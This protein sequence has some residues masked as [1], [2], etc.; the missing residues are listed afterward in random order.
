MENLGDKEP[1]GFLNKSIRRKKLKKNQ[2]RKKTKKYV[3]LFTASCNWKAPIGK[4]EIDLSFQ[5]PR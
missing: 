2:Q 3:N 1:L 4:I 5:L